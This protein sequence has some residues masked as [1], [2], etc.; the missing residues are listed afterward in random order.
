MIIDATLTFSENQVVTVTGF[1]LTA[2]N[3]GS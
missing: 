2:G 3:A 1:T